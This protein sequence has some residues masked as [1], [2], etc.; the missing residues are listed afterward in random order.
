MERFRKIS[1]A[2]GYWGY[3]MTR[4]ELIVRL[5]FAVLLTA[6][7]L[8]LVL[9]AGS[10]RVEGEDE[11]ECRFASSYGGAYRDVTHDGEYLYVAHV[12]GLSI[13]DVS[14][15]A[16]PEKIGSV[17]TAGDAEGVAV[18]GDYA[19]VADG[20]NGLVIIDITDKTDPQQVG[21][22]D[23]AGWANG[24]V[25]AGDYAYVAD[26]TNGLV[27]VNIS[28][29]KNPMEEGYYNTAGDAEGVAVSGDYAY[30][31]D[32]GGGLVVVDI[33]DKTKPQ[34]VG[35]YNTADHAYGVAVKG[36]YGYVVDKE[37]GL[38]IID[39]TDKTKPQ[40]V[41]HYDTAGEALGV[42]VAGDYAYVA[43]YWNSLVIVNIADRTKP[44]E[45]GHYNTADW[46]YGV[47]VMGD[48]AYAADGGGGLVIA[49][50]SNKTDPRLA[51][52]YSTAD[53]TRSVTVAGD[54][55][56]VADGP[57]GL[58]IVGISNKGNPQG[59]GH[60]NTADHAYG[61]AVEGD[62]A[63]VANSW[64][65]LVIV[66]ISN[67]TDPQEAGHYN[68]AG[69]AYGVAV[70]G[71]YAYVADRS[72]G[73]VIVDVT[74]K[75]DPQEVGH[76]NTSGDTGS[77]AVEGD[78][79]YVADR[80]NGLVII[81]IADKTDPQQVGHYNT[82]DWAWGV[83]V[84]GDYAYVADRYTGLIIVDISNKTDPQ[85]AGHY[86]T[87]DQA[88]GVAVAGDYAYVA[89]Y[90]S[91][92]VIVELA[93][94]A[95]IDEVSP[96][97]ALDTDTIHFEGHG[98]DDGTI[99]SHAWRIVNKAGG[100]VHNGPA[101]PAT[102]PAGTYTVYF[103]VRDNHGVWSDEVPERL[104]V[105]QR[106]TAEIISI[107]PSPARNDEEVTF[108]G[109][110]TDDGT[111]ER[112]IWT[113]SIDGE[114]FDLGGFSHVPLLELFSTTWCQYSPSAEEAARELNAE[115]GEHFSF[116]TMLTDVN[117]DAAARS[118][119][120]QVAG[121]PD[122]VFDGGYRRE[123]GR[124][125][126]T[127]TYEG[128]IEDCGTR[129]PL[130]PRVELAVE[131]VDNGDGTMDVSYTATCTEA[132]ALP[133]LDAHIRV[134]IVEKE[135][136]YL[137]IDESPIPYAF[138]DYAFD[139]DIRL[140]SQVEVSDTVTWDFSD[141]ENAAFDNLVV[142]AALFD[143]S[144]GVEG[145]AIQS[146]TAERSSVPTRTTLSPGVHTISYKVQDNYG[147]WS[148]EVSTTLTVAEPVPNQK[149][150]V[151]VTSHT[152]GSKVSG[153][154]T[155]SGTASDPDGTVARV[156]LALDIQAEWEVATGTDS[157]SHTRDTKQYEAGEHTLYV[158]AYDGEDYSDVVSYDF[159][160]VEEDDD[161]EAGFLTGFELT[162]L[163]AAMGAAI[164]C[165][166][167]K[168]L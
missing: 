136:R 101:P 145:H 5:T 103:R 22:Y 51:G 149:P 93:P 17:P 9:A 14:D 131:A 30:V 39:I 107:S 4:K 140:L 112:H 146:A 87:T 77:V 29:K 130:P 71:D 92:L 32:G 113:S 65:G 79:V 124:Q 36:D 108:K 89:D 168:R 153:V 3:F 75:T 118:D 62:Y 155:V 133:F 25:V 16:N 156:E 85:E 142:I 47:A 81:D 97:P 21:H 164:S 120:Y 20:D 42:A 82:A 114:L 100:E 167:K 129:D 45:A 31:A 43:D 57:N 161:D 165:S 106:P 147:V 13:F 90:R 34:E 50:I 95:W 148:D 38:V 157:W 37:N 66:D 35:R 127:D 11:I 49:D 150:T 119:H 121:V 68:T 53:W 74:D 137:D 139:E 160:V 7:V 52:H 96:S 141:D 94:V 24:V 15:P 64:S 158:R 134:Y 111:I 54:Y 99:D 159:T 27:I 78:Y 1:L 80:D 44:Q 162:L 144:T 84:E 154:V 40:E 6:F 143:K 76:Y 125:Y 132:L 116:V 115:Y 166:K 67:T 48:Y 2:C 163:A 109:R 152:N 63:Y 123:I 126:G 33:S 10:R 83:A 60:Y 56:Y 151:T 23:T 98:T 8:L 69:Q 72:N 102:L 26:N 61:V 122:A 138:L 18:A 104:I 12:Q 28:Y 19:Y 117:G 128:H 55:A 46:T 58:V 110:G 70:A 88:Q 59:T 86:D 105:H 41:G 91:G 73:L 135:S